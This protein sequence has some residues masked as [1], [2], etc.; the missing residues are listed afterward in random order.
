MFRAGAVLLALALVA[1]F[2]AAAAKCGSASVQVVVLDQGN[3]SLA[4]LLPSD[5]KLRIKNQPVNVAAV[6]YGIFPHNTVILVS[7]TGSMGQ[8]AKTELARQ[9]AQAATSGAPGTVMAGTFAGDVSGLMDAR[10]GQAYGGNLQP[11]SDE[12]NVLY[13]AILNGITATR[14]H[15]GD[16]IVAVTDSPDSGSKALAADVQHKLESTGA[17]LFVVALPPATEAG[18]MKPLV[19]LADFSG[20]AVLVPLR[21]DQ[22]TQSLAIS[23]EQIEAAVGNFSRAYTQDSNIYQLETD[24]EGQDRPLPLRVEVER[25]K[26]GGGKVLAPAMLAPCTAVGQ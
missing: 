18:S 22:T 4:G 2:P 11:G 20:G 10:A 17:R 3:N 16:A 25:H 14:M 24:S 12:K 19:D 13:D 8:S 9:I 26:I 21:V 6:D 5:F 1:P 7:R 15:R 23:A